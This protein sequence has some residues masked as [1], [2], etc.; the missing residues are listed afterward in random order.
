MNKPIFSKRNIFGTTI[1]L[2]IIFVF[3]ATKHLSGF[4]ELNL[5]ST[6]QAHEETGGDHGKMGSKGKGSGGKQDKGADDHGHDSGGS[7]HGENDTKTTGS[8]LGK[9]D[10]KRDPSGDRLSNPVIKGARV[11]GEV[12]PGGTSTKKGDAHSDK[13]VLVRDPVT[14][15]ALTE[16]LVINGVSRVFPVVQAFDAAGNPL[17]GISIPRDPLSGDLLTTLA[18]GTRVFVST[19]E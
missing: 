8:F 19:A 17:P 14:G 15:V 10:E 5:I 4:S 7:G 6:A 13:V 11:D 12:K 1:A 3:S 16:S 18:D 9:G 2:G